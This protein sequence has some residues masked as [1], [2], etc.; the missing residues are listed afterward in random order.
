MGTSYSVL[1]LRLDS[2]VPLPE[3]PV[4]TGDGAGAGAG[5][6]AGP[7]DVTV[8]LGSPALRAIP[9]VSGAEADVAADGTVRVEGNGVGT[10]LVR[11]GSEILVDARTPV[12]A[13]ALRAYVLGSALAVICHQRGLLPLHAA[14]LASPRGIILL[15][16]ESGAGKS[17]LSAALTARGLGLVAEDLAPLSWTDEA[18][19]PM[20]LPSVPRLKLS[21]E[22]LRRHGHA[23]DTLPELPGSGGKRALH[24]PPAPA[25]EVVAVCHLHKAVPGDEP[26][27]EPMDG[28]AVL[29]SLQRNVLHWPTALDLGRGPAVF[30]RLALLSRQVPHWR[31]RRLEGLDRLEETAAL[32]LRLTEGRA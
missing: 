18:R 11:N 16:G 22:A 19:P 1:G 20:A 5:A 31:L 6:G 21:P 32:V 28:M 12:A 25:G 14:A 29:A 30:R 17:T 8:R 26:H 2:E 10:F 4:R 27:L 23:P 13:P 7:A 15:V 3:L 9:F 24:L